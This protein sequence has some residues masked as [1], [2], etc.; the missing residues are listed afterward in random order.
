MFEIGGAKLS[1]ATGSKN[2][3]VRCLGVWEFGGVV[4]VLVFGGC[5]FGVCV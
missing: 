3:L 1:N 4:S 5:V 2:G